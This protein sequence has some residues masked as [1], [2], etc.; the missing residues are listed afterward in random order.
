L[1]SKTGVKLGVNLMAWTGSVDAAALELLPGIAELEYDGVELPVFVPEAVDA[2]AVRRALEASRL[3]ATV[4]T[5][6]SRGA[7]LLEPDQR[8]AGVEL[9][10]RI[11]AVAAECGASLVC[12]PIYAPV[13][14]LPG[15]PRTPAEWDSCVAGL[16]EAGERAA[17]HGVVLA[18]ELLNRFET[19]FLNT[20][21]DGLA[22]IAEVGHPNVTLHLDTFHLNIEEKSVPGAITRAGNSLT[23]VHAAENDR[24]IVGS[25]HI[26]WPGVAEALRQIGYSGWVTA[27][28]FT[29][30]IPEI[31]AATA[32]WRPIVP[33]GWTYA[34]ESL[35]TLQ[36][37]FEPI[38]PS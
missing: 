7:S 28:T 37:L 36:R 35:Q 14:Q 25:G 27:E 15:R 19:H 10:E 38:P 4:S 12:G 33:D 20:T 29:G 17:R 3:G 22:L 9:L 1:T 23:H 2:L 26:D 32:I 18:V 11:A 30:S 24:G 8:A 16:R 34:R 31:A 5:A 6:L 21:E 13:G